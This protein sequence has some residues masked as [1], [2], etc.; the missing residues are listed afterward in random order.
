[1][2]LDLLASQEPADLDL[3]WFQNGIN[4]VSHGKG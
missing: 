4:Q 1:M 2:D 3:H